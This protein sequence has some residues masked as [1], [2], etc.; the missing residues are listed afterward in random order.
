[1]TRVAKKG[2]VSV[3]V[4]TY[5]RAHLI[6][7]AIR[8]VQQQ[9]YTSWELIIVDDG[10]T[11]TT[12]EVL[13]SL[14][15]ER[16]ISFRIPHTGRIAVVR[17]E[18]MRHATGE[19]IAFLDSDDVWLPNKLEFQLGRMA[20]HPGAFFIFGHGR[21]FGN[22]A[23]PMPELEPFFYGRVF[24]PQL[25][26]HR[27]IFYAPTLLFKSDVLSS[28]LPLDENFIS[29]GDYDFFL[30]MAFVFDGI[31]CREPVAAIRLHDQNSTPAIEPASFENHLG[32]IKRF[33]QEGSLTRKQYV[34]LAS[35]QFYRR[36]V[37]MLR[38]GQSAAA[39]RYFRH[40]LRLR[41]A[42][43][44]AWVRLVQTLLVPALPD[45]TTATT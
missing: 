8:S 25:V 22:G 19:Y 31:F 14:R 12:Q 17:N 16:I 13:S 6:G 45:K 5:N 24:L 34:A 43:Y 44:K 36:G 7:D 27:F 26:D 10:S 42:N 33:F 15:D 29:G 20:E 11:D 30:R 3:V 32:M 9:T 40:H 18:C 21:Q 37:T 2:L 1:L 35:E 23:T 4:P 39:R 28:I 41:P 38:R